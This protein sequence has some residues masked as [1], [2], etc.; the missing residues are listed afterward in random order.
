VFTFVHGD[1]HGRP[2]LSAA[3]AIEDL[4]AFVVKDSDQSCPVGLKAIYSANLRN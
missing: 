2:P 4:S 3:W 1:P